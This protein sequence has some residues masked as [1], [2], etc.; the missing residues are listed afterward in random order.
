MG[1]HAKTDWSQVT[2]VAGVIIALAALVEHARVSRC[3]HP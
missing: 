2:G 1:K 3:T